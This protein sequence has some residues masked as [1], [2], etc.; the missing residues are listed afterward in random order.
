MREVL[1]L[2]CMVWWF[3]GGDGGIAMRGGSG[4]RRA[5]QR[6]SVCMC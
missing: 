3:V 6:S 5:L 2:V 4:L 1:T